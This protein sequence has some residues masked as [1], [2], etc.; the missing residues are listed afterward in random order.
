ML[1]CLCVL[2]FD[3]KMLDED[4][5]KR[6]NTPEIC[7]IIANWFEKI[8]DPNIN[9]ES[10]NI[11]KEFY[12]ADKFLEQKQTN[13][14]TFKSHPQAYHTSR[15][16]DFTKQLNEILNQRKHVEAKFSGIFYFIF[17]YYLIYYNLILIF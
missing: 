8:R 1:P 9:K 12:E 17:F 16:L 15:L 2:C 13:V 4:P 11:I 10:K 6:P 5:S 3:E 7:E 14:S